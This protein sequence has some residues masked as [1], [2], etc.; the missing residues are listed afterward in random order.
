MSQNKSEGNDDKKIEVFF[1]IFSIVL[2]MKTSL[3]FLKIFFL[4][5]ILQKTLT[6]QNIECHISFNVKAIVNY[7]AHEMRAKTRYLMSQKKK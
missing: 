4:F 6:L 2:H 7:A 5:E 1:D 3:I